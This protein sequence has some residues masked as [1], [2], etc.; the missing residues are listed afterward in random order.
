LA[1]VRRHWDLETYLFFC[2]PSIHDNHEST[3]NLFCKR[4][5]YSDTYLPTFNRP[6]VHLVD[7]AV[8]KGIERR[9]EERV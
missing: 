4:P 9:S 5:V 3:D 2:R 6:N 1:V 7:A 8:S